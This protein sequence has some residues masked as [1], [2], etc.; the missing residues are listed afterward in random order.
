VVFDDSFGI[1]ELTAAARNRF[2]HADVYVNGIA[3]EKSIGVYYLADW[4]HIS[5]HRRLPISAPIRM[6]QATRT[7]TLQVLK[8]RGDFL[9]P[10]EWQ[11]A[12]PDAGATIVVEYPTVRDDGTQGN[13]LWTLTRKVK[14]TRQLNRWY[15]SVNYKQIAKKLEADRCKDDWPVRTT[16]EYLVRPTA[17]SI[18][19]R[20]MSAPASDSP[21]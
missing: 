2:S 19:A 21:A 20:A 15:A 18:T 6:A 13:L 7:S 10:L 11:P 8:E 14:F 12:Q 16:A 17:V 3:E 5:E 1:E 9:E 4:T